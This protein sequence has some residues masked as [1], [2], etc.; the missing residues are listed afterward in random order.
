MRGVVFS[1][2]VSIYPEPSW[3]PTSTALGAEISQTD[4]VAISA[5]EMETR[6]GIIL[7]K[8]HIDGETRF[9]A[10]R[11]EGDLDC[12]DAIL[13]NPGGNALDMSR[14]EI[15]GAFFLRGNAKSNGA[16]VLTGASIGTIHDSESS[17][18]KKGDLLLNRC[19]YSGFIDSPVDARSRLDW[20]SRQTPERWGEDFWPQPYE[21][22]ASV[23]RE[24]GHVEDSRAVL[25]VKERLQRRARRSRASNAIWRAILLIVDSILAVTVRY[26]RQPLLAFVWLCLFWGLGRCR[27]FPCRTAGC[28]Q[29]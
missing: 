24:M 29:A 21:Q 5:P 12:T 1:M 4:G 17:W 15:K 2:A 26:G 14:M 27:L 19:R 23:F 16:L 20:L 25:I 8:A 3:L 7:R 9:V 11:I 13:N 28:F 22:L 10:S 6:G 18:P